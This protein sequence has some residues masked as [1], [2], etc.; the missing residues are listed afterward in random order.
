MGGDIVYREYRRAGATWKALALSAATF[1]CGALEVLVNGV[2]FW[3]ALLLVTFLLVADGWLALALLRGRT[4]VRASGI[5]AH[6]GVRVRTWSWYE[7]QDLRI[8]PYPR[9]EGSSPRLAA[10]LYDT[11]G[12]RVEL[13]F[14]NDRCVADMRAEAAFLRGVLAGGRGVA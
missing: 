8:E 1:A 13:P 12:H 10:F 9:A 11:A 2:P 5:T 3:L 14:V 7:V 4:V 6:N